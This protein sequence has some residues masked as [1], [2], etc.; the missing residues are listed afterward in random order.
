MYIYW[1][2]T[3]EAVKSVSGNPGTHHCNP[4]HHGEDER[5]CSPGIKCG[6]S[7]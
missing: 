3:P 4:Y 2:Y 7:V 1:L 6:A 5:L